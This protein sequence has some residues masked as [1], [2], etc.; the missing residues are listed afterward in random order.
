[1]KIIDCFIFYN[2]IEM[3]N[4]R[5][6]ILDEFVDFF[7]LV[8]S[9]HTH[10]GKPKDLYFEKNKEKFEKFKDKIIHIIVDDFPFIYPNIDFNNEEQWKNEHFQ[11]NAIKRGIDKIDMNLDDVLIISDLDEIPDTNLINAIKN[12]SFGI[13]N[14]V[15]SLE[16]NFFY[17]NLNSLHKNKWYKAKLVSY[18]TYLN[19]KSSSCE[20][21]RSG[22]SEIFIYN[23]GWHLSYF[24]DK[25]F[26][27]NKLQNFTHQEYNNELYTNLEN[28]QKRIE[29]REGFNETLNSISVKDNPY[30][31][32]K[33]EEY[34]SSFYS[35]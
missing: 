25:Y 28:I 13:K 23:G 35:F 12:D 7:V 27:Q 19:S 5:L 24:G 33:Y 21:I 30:L 14:H 29:T 4:Y 3:L 6:N 26:I 16:Q 10:I 34:L 32:H 17:Y 2:E 18:D 8:E 20:E 11:R 1:M 22:E 15:Y 31:P 9:T